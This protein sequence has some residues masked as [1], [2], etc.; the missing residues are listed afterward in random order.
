MKQIRQQGVF[1]LGPYKDYLGYAKY[2][3]ESKL[4]HGEVS[5]LRDVVTFQGKSVDELSRSFV[6][7]IDD[8]LDFCK[9]RGEPPERPIFWKVPI[10][11]EA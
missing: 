4:W 6:D 9:F 11:I 8:Y 2:D 10:A 1:V 3:A 7:S 5:G